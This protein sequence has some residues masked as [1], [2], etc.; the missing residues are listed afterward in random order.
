MISM[1]KILNNVDEQI[2]KTI[3]LC[4]ELQEVDTLEKWLIDCEK[5]IEYR[6]TLKMNT[7]S[8]H[9]EKAYLQTVLSN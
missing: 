5:E 9:C 2:I 8:L 4:V 7:H 3:N 1:E 6:K